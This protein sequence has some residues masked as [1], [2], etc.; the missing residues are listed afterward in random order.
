MNILSTKSLA[1]VSA[2]VLSGIFVWIQLDYE[3]STSSIEKRRAVRKAEKKARKKAR[4]NYWQQ[5]LRDPKTGK[6]PTYAQAKALYHT[7]SLPD[8]A[9]ARTEVDIE[10]NWQGA[11]PDR[12][13]GRV[14][15]FA[16]DRRNPDIMLAGGVTGGM[17]KSSNGGESWAF[18]SDP[19]KNLTVSSLAQD[20]KSP[21]TW[22]HSSG[23][24]GSSAGNEDAGANFLGA[25]GLFKSTN[26]GD[27]WTFI[28]YEQGADN[29]EWKSAGNGLQFPTDQTQNPFYETTRIRINPTTSS[30]FVGSNYFGVLRSDDGGQTFKMV[31]GGNYDEFKYFPDIAIDENG[32]IVVAL[33]GLKNDERGIFRSTDNGETWTNITPNE[34][35]EEFE[36]TVLAIAPSNPNTLF[37]MTT[38]NQK[39]DGVEEVLLFKYDLN[40]GT[41]ENRSANIPNFTEE[42]SGYNG[43]DTQS[44]YNMVLA[45]HPTNENLVM[46]GGVALYRSRDGF[47]TKSTDLNTSVIG[48][49]GTESAGTSNQF[50]DYNKHFPD[51][52]LIVFDP[53]NPNL[54]YSMNDGGIHKTNDI[55]AT[56]VSWTELD[57]NFAVTQF[58]RAAISNTAGDYRMIGGCQDNGSA[59]TN[60]NP[61]QNFTP[62][63]AVQGADGG[64]P[65]IG[66]N[67]ILASTQE[68]GIN[69]YEVQADKTPNTSLGG[70]FIAM[71]A[72][73]EDIVK[74]KIFV[75]PFAID[76]MDEN[77]MYLP[78]GNEIWK[79]SKLQ[80]S[81][82]IHA[83]WAKMQGIASR[84]NTTITALAMSRQP[85]DILYFTAFD[86]AGKPQ[87]FR[88]D[89]AKTATSATEISISEATS[90]AYPVYIAVNPADANEIMVVFANYN[91]IGLYHSTDGGQSYTA[92]EGNL[93]GNSGAGPSLRSAAILNYDGK[94]VYYV[95]TSTGLFST[96]KL[97]GGQTQ[98]L[99]EAK[100]TIGSA[101]I[102]E[103]L[104]RDADGFVAVSTH[105]RSNFVGLP[106]SNQ[107]QQPEVPNTPIALNAENVGETEFTAKWNSVSGAASYEL[108]V[109]TNSN[110]SS[111]VAG[112]NAKSVSGTSEKITGLTENINY[113]YRVRAKNEGG[114]SQNSNVISVQTNAKAIEKPNAPMVSSAESVGETEFTAKWNSVSGATSYELDVSTNSNFN[115]FVVGYNAKSVL[116]NSMKVTGLTENTNYFYRVRAKNEGGISNNS[117]TIEVTTLQVTVSAIEEDK[118]VMGI[119]L[120]PNPA[121]D[122]LQIQ[123]ENS[124]YQNTP[125]QCRIFDINGKLV[126]QQNATLSTLNQQL[127]LKVQSFAKGTYLLRLTADKVKFQQRFI[128]Q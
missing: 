48:G 12:I 126:F 27:T 60:W 32:N 10:L 14:R 118:N 121:T 79:N 128:K 63:L 108:D 36:R 87:V 9:N 102:A 24:F 45:I 59:F 38:T 104:T 124:A 70:T 115:S 66:E 65:Y 13:G 71:N 31:L 109:S 53:N 2:I 43:I 46:I 33:A 55:T 35:P 44:N 15:A 19:N 5:M 96:S 119:R 54:M 111:F 81:S 7:Q 23:E 17:W 52:H 107:T 39:I 74:N 72:N 103:V 117:N 95:G 29:K 97:D 64:T 100:S 62:G 77:M 57:G 86:A 67:F 99:Q 94:K 26:N 34:F 123:M 69:M 1:I 40:T 112:Y 25:S 83:D 50:G 88:V 47:A 51:Q 85:Q 22:Y 18:K 4:A 110:F 82:E 41:A 98:W 6:I 91:I 114:T 80:T 106:N 89:N 73:D 21:D 58:Y 113:F 78:D 42:N 75:H 49:L 16:I 122:I 127:R 3:W 84:E 30:I 90:G 76:P 93:E 92:I 105:G 68:A 8:M 125:I 120:F 101:V 37:S 20:P 61:E 56:Q 116:G 11:G 28:A